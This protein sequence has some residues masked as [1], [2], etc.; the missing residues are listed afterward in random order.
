M[1]AQE[2]S[3]GLLL[4]VCRALLGGKTW[5]VVFFLVR[6]V[7]GR[8]NPRR[9]YFA[10][11]NL[12]GDTLLRGG[13]PGEGKGEGTWKGEPRKEALFCGI[14]GRGHSALGVFERR[15]SVGGHSEGAHSAGEYCTYNESLCRRTFY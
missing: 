12:E 4:G 11:R 13:A 6:E 3:F 15:R 1:S 5:K 14:L 2:E 8:G 7:P 9:M 10:R